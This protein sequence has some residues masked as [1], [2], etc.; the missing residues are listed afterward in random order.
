M[1][2]VSPTVRISSTPGTLL[3]AIAASAKCGS[4]A[5]AR[6]D[7]AHGYRAGRDALGKRDHVGRHAVTLGGECMA[8]PTKA[9]DHFVEDQQNAVAVADRAQPFEITFGR[10]QHAGRAGHRLDDDGGNGG[11]IMQ[12]DEAFEIV[13]E[14]RA[15]LRLTLGESLM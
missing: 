3:S 10:W 2:A 14:M 7:A 1:P 4:S 9:G 13:G 6:D 12:R 5:L 8:E 11:S 15:P